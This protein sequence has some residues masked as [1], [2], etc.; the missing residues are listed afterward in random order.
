MGS[1]FDSLIDNSPDV[2]LPARTKIIP[3]IVDLPV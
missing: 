1:E 3:P 2:G